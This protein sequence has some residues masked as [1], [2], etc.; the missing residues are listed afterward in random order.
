MK[1][2]QVQYTPD[3][4]VL[5]F[6]A[7]LTVRRQMIVDQQEIIR[8]KPEIYN[9][10]VIKDALMRS[11]SDL[12]FV[13]DNL[14]TIFDGNPV[15]PRERKAI[16]KRLDYRINK[17]QHHL[18]HRRVDLIM[19]RNRYVMDQLNAALARMD[20]LNVVHPEH[21]FDLIGIF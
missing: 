12:R 14:R 1:T 10:P 15:A 20:D 7:A 3:D 9:T 2:K 17:F 18:N 16:L 11:E 21:T 5:V 13:T 8:R 6:R 4:P 19:A